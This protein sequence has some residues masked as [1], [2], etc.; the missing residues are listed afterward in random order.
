VAR[1][2]AGYAISRLGFVTVRSCPEEQNLLNA[3]ARSLLSL[4]LGAEVTVLGTTLDDH[5]L[6]QIGNTF[7]TGPIDPREFGM[8]VRR[9]SLQGLFLAN[10]R[11]I[12][13]HPITEQAFA[14][15]LPIGYFD[16]SMGKLKPRK[17]DLALNPDWPLAKVATL[18]A[19]WMGQ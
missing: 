11:P 16:W 5:S 18:F 15:G 13:G 19:D 8:L 12:F 2:R 9:Y 3:L 1:R 17:R 6:M 7:V 14:C 4:R 10:A